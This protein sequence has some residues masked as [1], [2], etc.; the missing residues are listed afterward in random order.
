MACCRDHETGIGLYGGSGAL[1][2]RPSRT[3]DNVPTHGTLAM[4]P[5]TECTIVLSVDMGSKVDGLSESGSAA[6]SRLS[7]Q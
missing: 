1:L 4:L 7:V 5:T 6:L 2:S 3:N